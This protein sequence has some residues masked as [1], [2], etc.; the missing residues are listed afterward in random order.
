MPTSPASPPAEQLPVRSA[1]VWA[2]LDPVVGTGTPLRV[3]DV[4]G[5]SGMFA[6]PLARL[7]HDVTVVDPSAD[8]LATLRR[9]ADTAGVVGTL[10]GVGGRRPA[11]RGA[12][13]GDR[14]GRVRPRALPLGARGRRRPG[15][16]PQR[17]RPRRPL[18]RSGSLAATN[19]AGAVLARAVSGHP[20]EALALH[21]AVIPPRTAAARAADSPPPTCSP[22][23]REPGCAGSTWRGVSVVAD[24]LD[25][26]SGAATDAVRALELAL[27]E[28]SPYRDVAT[29]LHVLA[30]RP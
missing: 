24:L 2:A 15:R 28:T 11:A 20:V 27:A 3:L 12:A 26:N 29:G 17:D 21:E 18:R 23:S 14:R 9:R 7:G 1:A 22:S 25:A 30:A 4:G 8:A 19:R 6:V 13:P 16:D 5:G 10:R